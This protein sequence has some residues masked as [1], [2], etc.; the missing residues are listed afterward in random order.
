MYCAQSHSSWLGNFSLQRFNLLAS[1]F[2]FAS[3]GECWLLSSWEQ[4]GFFD[5]NLAAS[6]LCTVHLKWLEGL[7]LLKSWRGGWWEWGGAVTPCLKV[8]ETLC[9]PA[10]AEILPTSFHVG[11]VPLILSQCHRERLSLAH[12]RPFCGA[13]ICGWCKINTGIPVTM[14]MR[15]GVGHRIACNTP[16]PSK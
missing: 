13:T 14:I 8:W 11:D 5:L 1:A 6:W 9:C 3:L 10:W 12:G 16:P 4:Y 2:I 15:F 7:S